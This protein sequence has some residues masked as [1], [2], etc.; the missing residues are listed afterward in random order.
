MGCPV[1]V[2]VTAATQVHKL[3]TNLFTSFVIKILRK[4]KKNIL[5]IPSDA[6]Q[7]IQFSNFASSASPLRWRLLL[8]LH[9]QHRIPIQILPG[10]PLKKLPPSRGTLRSPHATWSQ[11]CHCPGALVPV[12][13]FD[14]CT[15]PI[16]RRCH[17]HR[18][19]ATT[20]AA[21]GR[22]TV[23]HHRLW[24]CSVQEERE[25]ASRDMLESKH[26]V[27]EAVGRPSWHHIAEVER[28]EGLLV[29]A[30]QRPQ[31][32]FHDCTQESVLFWVVWISACR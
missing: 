2:H 21:P 29:R 7:I 22:Q 10:C 13:N 3:Y 5:S 25:G 32:L 18:K 20:T 24:Q 23:G 14:L 1:G 16:V 27:V 26:L 28:F 30:F 31:H 6:Q 15:T 8:V 12:H 9:R 11:G 4:K 17:G 19:F